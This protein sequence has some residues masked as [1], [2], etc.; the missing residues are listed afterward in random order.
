PRKPLQAPPQASP[1]RPSAIGPPI[2][3]A[4]FSS[5]LP[6]YAPP[7]FHA[8]FRAQYFSAQVV[9]LYP[10]ADAPHPSHSDAHWP[11]PFV[12]HQQPPPPNATIS[13]SISG[14]GPVSS[15]TGPCSSKLSTSSPSPAVSPTATL[16]KDLP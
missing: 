1:L 6:S 11:D 12:R 16:L 10:S 15:A 4:G 7:S 3:N 2:R 9:P 5:L 8:R 14:G 13:A